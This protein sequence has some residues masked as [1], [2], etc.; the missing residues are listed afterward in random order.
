[1][2][3][4]TTRAAV[5]GGLRLLRAA[6]GPGSGPPVLLLHPGSFPLDVYAGLVDALPDRPAVLAADLERIPAYLDPALHPDRLPETEIGELAEQVL[7]WCAGADLTGAVLV[8]WSFGGTVALDV[9][10]RLRSSVAGLVVLDSLAP[11]PE[12]TLPP[13]E[14]DDGKAVDWFGM[15]IA[16][17]RDA[18]LP[19]APPEGSTEDRLSALLAV[20]LRTGAFL[21]G[22]AMPGIRKAFRAYTGGLHR[23][24][25]LSRRYPPCSGVDVPVHLVRPAR[26]MVRKP[27]A[28]GWD[29]VATTVTVH[30]VPGDHYSMLGEP[31]T[32]TLVAELCSDALGAGTRNGRCG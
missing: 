29:Q 6:G 25:L 1:M 11:V 30:S 24:N 8:G 21:P 14:F 19:A 28:L 15:Y 26:G 27:G 18:P 3:V 16:A 31:E 22:T 4:E 23:N 17:K 7:D 13:Q 5:T 32:A 9:V 2:A 20:G 10:R 12:F